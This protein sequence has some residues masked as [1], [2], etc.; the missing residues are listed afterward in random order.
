MSGITDKGVNHLT[1]AHTNNNW[2][3]KSLSLPK[4]AVSEKSKILINDAAKDKYCAV[5]YF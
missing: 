1:R 4:G 2:K 3:L 5:F